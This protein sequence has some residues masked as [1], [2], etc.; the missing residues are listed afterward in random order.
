MGGLRQQTPQSF[1]TRSHWFAVSRCASSCQTVDL[2]GDVPHLADLGTVNRD[3]LGLTIGGL[4]IDR[5]EFLTFERVQPLG[6]L[7][8]QGGDACA[9]NSRAGTRWQC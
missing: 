7:A 9:G 6:A 3:V 5:H 1:T 8:H 4:Q 2:A